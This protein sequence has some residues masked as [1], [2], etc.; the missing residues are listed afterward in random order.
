MEEIFGYTIFR[1]IRLFFVEALMEGENVTKKRKMFEVDD[2]DNDPLD[3]DEA[4]NC[5]VAYLDIKELY[6]NCSFYY[7]MTNDQICELRYLPH[8][9]VY[10]GIKGDVHS[11]GKINDNTPIILSKK[12]IEEDSNA[13]IRNLAE[14]CREKAAKGIKK[15]YRVGEGDIID[16]AIPMWIEDYPIVHYQQN[17][18]DICVFS[19]LS[20]CLHFLGCIEW[21]E[22]IF[23]LSFE[24]EKRVHPTFIKT[25]LNYVIQSCFNLSNFKKFREVYT[26]KKLK[27]DE[28][29]TSF[30]FGESDFWLVVPLMSDGS[31]SHCICV[32][33]EWIFDGNFPNALPFTN[34]SLDFCCGQNCNFVSVSK[35]YKFIYGERKKR[36]SIFQMK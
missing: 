31:T 21:A 8:K 25:P 22:S 14:I 10:Y 26:I 29:V 34:E 18:R 4:E 16:V 24:Y 23:R 36:K 28:K 1:K 17:G 5:Y 35:G 33:K 9:E 12:Y 7:N 20:S 32:T 13:T 2:L 27:K 30:N 3:P 6:P 11:K 19:S 15:F